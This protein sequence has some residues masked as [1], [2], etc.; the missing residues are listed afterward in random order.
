MPRAKLV[1]QVR[2]D[3]S[4]LGVAEPKVF[5]PNDND[6]MAAAAAEM[7]MLREDPGIPSFEEADFWLNHGKGMGLD[8]DGVNRCLA[9]FT[10][11][12]NDGGFREAVIKPLGHLSQEA[13]REQDQA[14]KEYKK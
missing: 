7:V 14:W 9:L 12:Y 5:L 4:T 1:E 13:L 2:A 11:F 10:N 8:K 6:E 3:M